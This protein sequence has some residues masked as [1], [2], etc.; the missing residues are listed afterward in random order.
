VKISYICGVCVENDAI[1]TS[2]RDEILWLKGYGSNDVRLYGYMCAF[3][4]LSFIKV[5]HLRDIIFDAHFQCS[6][7]VV[8]HFG[9]YYQLFDSLAVT[10]K[11]AKRVVVFH[12]ITPR[13]HVAA[14][15]HET[16]DRSFQQM[17][18]IQLA[19]RVICD[20][21]TNLDVLRAA[22][23][24]TPAVVLSLAVHGDIDSPERKPSH[25][26]GVARICFVGRFVQS[27]G[28]AE[29]LEAVK[30]V[31]E[32]DKSIRLQ[33]DMIGNLTFSDS[34]LLSTVREIITQMGRCYGDRGKVNL[35][36]NATEKIKH[37]ILRDADLFV[38]PTYHE[39]FCVPIVEAL[40]GG[41]KVITY[42]NTN[43]PAISGGLA[44][45]IP[46]GD[47]RGLA[48]AIAEALDEITSPAWR[49]TGS[50]SYTDFVQKARAHVL[51]YRPEQ[52]KRRFLAFLSNFMD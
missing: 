17:S 44:R 12:N 8:F 15:G 20:S 33:L 2:I 16:I 32:R 23:I 22:G 29:L 1:S 40:A 41:S 49:G 11:N 51:Q 45:L 18:N 46:T 36:G 7:L 24:D 6:D 42:E 21:Q 25:H 26:D 14:E 28:P 27:K 31:L 48:R 39:G 19:D 38:L 52:V 34:I 13:E 3:D 47:V 10:P 37:K 35:L 9:V 4:D 30:E 5:N 50:D 43:T